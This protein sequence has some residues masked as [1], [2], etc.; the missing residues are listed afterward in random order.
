[1]SDL[2]WS[3]LF[4]TRNSFVDPAEKV[5]KKNLNWSKLFSSKEISSP[6]FASISDAIGKLEYNGEEGLTSRTNNKGAVLY[7]D[8]LGQKYGA[9]KGPK[10]PSK[11]NPDNRELYT[12]IFPNK[13]NG[14][15]A[16]MDVIK[17]IYNTSEGDI[18][19][20]PAIKV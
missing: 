10:L 4:S 5:N 13:E 7:T 3:K 9:V 11:D 14:D 17:N 1:M 12:A 16:S 20:N 19:K 15:K 6:N 18:E 2:N 8:E